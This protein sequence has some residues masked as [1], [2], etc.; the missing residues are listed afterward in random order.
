[1]SATGFPFHPP[2]TMTGGLLNTPVSLPSIGAQLKISVPGASLYNAGRDSNDR[3][4][5]TRD[6]HE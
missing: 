4:F 5:E 1:M 3:D 2:A 6:V